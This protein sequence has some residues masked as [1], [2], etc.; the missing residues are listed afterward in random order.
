MQNPFTL[1]LKLFGITI[2]SAF[3]CT[4]LVI[5]ITGNRETGMG[6]GLI[7]GVVL[8]DIIT[9][10]VCR[11]RWLFII[12]QTL[13]YSAVLAGVGYSTQHLPSVS[14]GDDSLGL[15]VMV[16][17]MMISFFVANYFAG[18]M[19]AGRLKVPAEGTQ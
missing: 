17:A 4:V 19:V 1:I 9:L 18:R 7:A 13:L 2:L 3:V 12:I 14:P 16:F 15:V 6:Y 5:A 11:Q 10:L 8:G